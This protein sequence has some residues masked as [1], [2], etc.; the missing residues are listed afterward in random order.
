SFLERLR[1]SSCGFCC[2]TAS[3]RPALWWSK[4]TSFT[5]VAEGTNPSSPNSRLCLRMNS[6]VILRLLVR[7][8]RRQRG[9]SRWR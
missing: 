3:P 2:T 6:Q 8:R 5:A 9:G 1:G 4:C 7:A